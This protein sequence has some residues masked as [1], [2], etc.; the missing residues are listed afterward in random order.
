MKEFL[1]NQPARLDW[2]SPDLQEVKLRDVLGQR[3]TMKNYGFLD[4]KNGRKACPI[5][6][7]E[8]PGRFIWATQLILDDLQQLDAHGHH[9]EVCD[10]ETHFVFLDGLTKTGR[11]FYGL[12]WVE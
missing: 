9:D 1:K 10:G 5:E 6:V 2:F 11:H 3:F 12:Q 7:Y 8:M 4:A